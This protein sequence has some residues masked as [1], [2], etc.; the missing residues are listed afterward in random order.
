MQPM[1]SAGR[2][3]RSRPCRPLC[4]SFIGGPG[5]ADVLL[6]PAVE[7]LDSALTALDTARASLEQAVRESEFDQAELDRTEDRLFRLRGASRKFGVP[8]SELAALR[9]RFAADLAGLE[10]GE[11][12]LK[13]QRAAMA[14]AEA[15]YV[16]GAETLSAARVAAAAGLESAVAAELPP[17]RLERARFMARLETDRATRDPSGFDRVEFWVQTNPGAR[18]GRS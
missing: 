14:V 5:Q 3:H 8:A 4:A 7:A 18:A 1:R 10:Q 12:D 16:R 9:D 17:L 15:D 6:A 13:Q 2:P 11:D